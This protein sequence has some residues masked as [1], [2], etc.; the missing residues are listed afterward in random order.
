MHMYTWLITVSQITTVSW[1]PTVNHL[2][3]TQATWCTEDRKSFSETLKIPTN[4]YRELVESLA[5]HI[6]DRFIMER[7]L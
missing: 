1:L 2:H 3:N 5:I 7:V 6:Y 4:V